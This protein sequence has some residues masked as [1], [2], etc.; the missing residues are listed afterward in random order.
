[1]KGG[2][3]TF[4]GRIAR[5]RAD[6]RDTLVH[7]CGDIRFPHTNCDTSTYRYYRSQS[8]CSHS[9]CSHDLQAHFQLQRDLA[10]NMRSHQPLSWIFLFPPVVVLNQGP[11]CGTGAHELTTQARMRLECCEHSR[12]KTTELRRYLRRRLDVSY[13]QAP[14]CVLYRLP[15]IS[16]R[17]SKH[18]RFAG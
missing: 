14:K 18:S 9:L 6:V 10:A 1:M 4:A 8:S 13:F 3:R 11:R 16:V 2:W 15:T 5:S 12:T 17:R 7:P